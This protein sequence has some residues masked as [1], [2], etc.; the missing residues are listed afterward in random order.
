MRLLWFLL[1]AQCSVGMFWMVP[2]GMGHNSVGLLPLLIFTFG[3]LSAAAIVGLVQAVRR[4]EL[5]VLALCVAAVPAVLFLLPLLARPLLAPQ[6]GKQNPFPPAMVAAACVGLVP[7]VFAPKYVATYLPARAVASKG[8]HIL[9]LLAQVFVFFAVP[10]AFW[11]ILQ[12]GS[13]RSTTFILS[14]GVPYTLT[15]LATGGFALYG[16]FHPARKH[17]WL[18][19]LLLLGALFLLAATVLV[20]VVMAV[21]LVNPG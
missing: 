18:K 11:V 4:P 3:P 9:L 6:L 14:L 15:G 16:L 21:L 10:A 17:A 12:T 19:V 1:V 2:V 20:Y 5:R 13:Q 7:L 8:A